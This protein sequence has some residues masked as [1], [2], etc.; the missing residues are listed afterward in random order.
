MRGETGSVSTCG[1]RRDRRALAVVDDHVAPKPGRHDSPRSLARLP[2]A[3]R[4]EREGVV[5]DRPEAASKRPLIDVHRY[6]LHPRVRLR[7]EAGGLVAVQD[8]GGGA[9]G[10]RDAI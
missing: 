7:A 8:D 4:I 2:K 6:D 9:R 3:R 10:S 1:S 5:T